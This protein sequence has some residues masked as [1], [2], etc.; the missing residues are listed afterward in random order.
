MSKYR[1]ISPLVWSDEKFRRLS[2]KAKLIWFLLLT[3]PYQ[4]SVG[5]MRATVEG[6]AAELQTDFESFRRAFQELVALEM[7]V[8]DRNNSLVLLPNSIKYNAP[9]N[10]NIV[11]AWRKIVGELPNCAIKEVLVNNIKALL[12]EYPERFAEAFAIPSRTGMPIQVARSK[13]QETSNK[14]ENT[15]EVQLSVA[16]SVLLGECENVNLSEHEYNELVKRLGEYGAREAIN[17]LSDM[18]E[19]N[20]VEYE[21]HFAMILRFDNQDVKPPEFR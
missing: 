16:P 19:S 15:T 20:G 3:H 7:V 4:T 14:K 10:S 13:K 6:L 5:V 2:E 1:K 17:Q 9:E 21:N 18:I 12:E 11:T 8:Y